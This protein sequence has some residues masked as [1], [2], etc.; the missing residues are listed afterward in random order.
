M[1]IKDFMNVEICNA[2]FDVNWEEKLKKEYDFK[3]NEKSIS[4]WIE[5]WPVVYIIHKKDRKI[6]YVGETINL[7]KRISDHLKSVNKNDLKLLKIVVDPTFNKS[8]IL[9]L[10]SQLIQLML[11][12]GFELRNR[13]GGQYAH[14]YFNRKEYDREF[15]YIWNKLK[16][17]KF[18]KHDY[19]YLVNS[20]IYKLS[21]YKSLDNEQLTIEE[22]VLKTIFKDMVNRKE[23][24][25]VIEGG[26][27]TGKSVLAVHML[28]RVMDLYDEKNIDKYINFENSDI[29]KNN[30][31]IEKII[32]EYK[33]HNDNMKIAIIVPMRRF[34]STMERIVNR[35]NG[36][37]NNV[38]VLSAYN[39][40]NN[41]TDVKKGK[42]IYK[43]KENE[44]DLVIVDE[45]HRL[46]REDIAFRST[47]K[48]A[49]KNGTK[50]FDWIKRC[51]KNQ[52]FFYD[53]YQTVRYTDDYELKNVFDN[54]KNKPKYY[55]ELKIQHRCKGG[56]KYL[57]FIK[58]ILNEKDNK[59]TGK[60]NIK[61]F[62]NADEM[63]NVIKDID[64][65]SDNMIAR[66]VS[67]ITWKNRK[68]EYEVLGKYKW[69]NTS[70]NDWVHSKDAHNEIGCIH[71][72]QGYDINY[73]GVIIGNELK[74]TKEKGIYVDIDKYKDAKKGKYSNDYESLKK[75]ILNIYYVLL[76]R[77]I[78]GTFV[79]ACDKGFR[80]YLKQYIETYNKKGTYYEERDNETDEEYLRVAEDSEGYNIT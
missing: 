40:V 24:F 30:R 3:I 45:S 19:D 70:V 49:F 72:V 9:D 80:N 52:I 74:Y 64:N 10:E 60:Y 5:N 35:V 26:P 28:K 6:A 4:Q 44:F 32:K 53:R 46:S 36:L 11:A 25:C 41:D 51:S 62:E 29:R 17:K 69:N 18:V 75:D 1:N 68:G 56:E 34:R 55:Y 50:Q 47:Y 15:K 37:K 21:P 22:N 66:N 14:D 58:D 79:Y 76:T 13:N 8:V 59:Y 48:E 67:G 23:S 27:G 38:E 20:N 39:F 77:G 33:K 61:L 12:D 2:I 7:V 43:Y 73:T 71:T 16:S 57:R 78:D 54:M 63:I 65:C 31:E 42:G